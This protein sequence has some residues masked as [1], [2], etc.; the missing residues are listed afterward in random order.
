MLQGWQEVGWGT[1]SQG[2]LEKGCTALALFLVPWERLQKQSLLT[3][4]SSCIIEHFLASGCFISLSRA[5]RTGWKVAC[6]C[7]LFWKCSVLSLKLQFLEL[8][9]ENLGLN[10]PE[11]SESLPR[12]SESFCM[13]RCVGWGVSCPT[14]CSRWTGHNSWGKGWSKAPT[15]FLSSAWK[16][17]RWRISKDRPLLLRIPFPALCYP[18]GER[19][20]ILSAPSWQSVS[21]SYQLPLLCRF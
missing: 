8:L 10:S 12:N 4:A 3:E 9:Q 7:A 16:P 13:K 6:S 17:S 18:P 21:L 5:G 1:Y 20:I 11:I 19:D 2:A 14:F 15:A